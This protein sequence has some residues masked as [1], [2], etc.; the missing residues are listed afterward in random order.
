MTAAKRVGVMGGTFD[1]FHR[2]HV[3]LG[4]AA[5]SALGLTRLLVLPVNVPPHRAQPVAS[6]HH[7]FAMA[8]MSVAGQ[9]GWE[10]SDLELQTSGFSYSTD[11]LARLLTSGHDPRELF[12]VIGA[13]AFSEV[14][15]WKNYPSLLDQAHFAVVSRPGCR[16]DILASKLPGLADRM[17]T[18]MESEVPY[19]TS[20]IL[21]D[22]VTSQVSS[23]AIR[24]RLREGQSIEGLVV[25]GVAQHI[26]QH[27]L[28]APDHSGRRAGN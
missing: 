13:D 22:A 18:W 11:T 9:S 24:Q 10:V 25:P 27:G 3:D 12:F 28:Y 2:G 26:E 4:L 7:R 21:I 1:P 23:T 14:E 8:A 5:V 6:S 19:P 17:V 20:I 16:V 15:T